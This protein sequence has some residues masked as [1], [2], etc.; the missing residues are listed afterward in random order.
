MLPSKSLQHYV[1]PT[2]QTSNYLADM[3]HK[4]YQQLMTAFRSGVQ[5]LPNPQTEAAY[6]QLR[7]LAR[8]YLPYSLRQS[9]KG[10]FRYLK[11]AVKDTGWN[12][13]DTLDSGINLGLMIGWGCN[14][15]IT[16]NTYRYEPHRYVT[17][18]LE[19]TQA[20]AISVTDEQHVIALIR[21]HGAPMEQ[22]YLGKG[23]N[24]WTPDQLRATALERFY[25]RLNVSLHLAAEGLSLE[26]LILEEGTIPPCVQKQFERPKAEW[27]MVSIIIPTHDRAATLERML[28][29]LQKLYYPGP[30]E[31]I[32]VDNRPSDDQTER[33]VAA[34]EGVRYL[35]E[36]RSLGSWGARNSGIRQVKGDIIAFT[37]DDT[38]IEPQWLTALVE[39]FLANPEIKA[40]TGPAYPGELETEAQLIF[41]S[42]ATFSRG[43]WQRIFTLTE[44]EK[45][46]YLPGGVSWAGQG[47]NMAFRREVFEE[48]GPFDPILDRHTPARTGGDIEMFYRVLRAGYKLVYE[49]KAMMYHYHRRDREGLK[50]QLRLYGRGRTAFAMKVVLGDSLMRVKALRFMLYWIAWYQPGLWLSGK[51]PR[52]LIWAEW[53]QNFLGIPGYLLAR[54][55][56]R[57]K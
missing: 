15:L 33:L 21:L 17:F 34:F 4:A 26:T 47:C 19:N 13:Q 10:T 44:P 16:L 56:N 36:D 27:P 14:N 12:F 1:Q 31:I 23:P 24:T 20:E 43:E 39:T 18:D 6:H 41:E 42:H 32:I 30:K 46:S 7:Q 22:I 3:V 38:K 52:D 48:I 54:W 8:S 11:R 50:A 25:L 57:R 2:N 55:Q 29:S 49:P 45:G 35:R 53:S 28:K 37:D 51:L 40:V 9:L 5:R